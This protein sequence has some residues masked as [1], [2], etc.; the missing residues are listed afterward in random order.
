MLPC[1]LVSAQ[2]TLAG[3]ANGEYPVVRLAEHRE[4]FIVFLVGNESVLISIQAGKH[5]LFDKLAR[6]LLSRN[7]SIHVLVGS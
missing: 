1:Q 2:N 3:R 5:S 4:R 6:S 7:F